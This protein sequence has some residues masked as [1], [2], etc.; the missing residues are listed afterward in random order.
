MEL[1][2]ILKENNLQLQYFIDLAQV[3]IKKLESIRKL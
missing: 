3:R 2:I 1:Y